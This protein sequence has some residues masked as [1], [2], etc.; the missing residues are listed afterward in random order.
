MK[1]ALIKI[2]TLA[3]LLFCSNL[4]NAKTT[5]N[6]NQRK[7]LQA[8]KTIFVSAKNMRVN[9]HKLIPMYSLQTGE[10]LRAYHLG[11]KFFNPDHKVPTVEDLTD[12]IRSHPFFI[13]KFTNEPDHEEY[14][15]LRNKISHPF[16]ILETTLNGNSDFYMVH[17]RGIRHFFMTTQNKHL[18][19][20]TSFSNSSGKNYPD[21]NSFI[22]CTL[23]SH[24]DKYLT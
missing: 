6:I 10:N 18:D 22:K 12:S 3:T 14:A 21:L 13:G 19:N 15:I 24:S 8:N 20:L 5:V 7:K 23:E 17:S 1:K 11:L 2:I 9:I 16:F 4:A